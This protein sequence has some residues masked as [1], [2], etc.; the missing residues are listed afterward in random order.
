MQDIFE[1]LSELEQED[2]KEL[3]SACNMSELLN[4]KLTRGIG[5]ANYLEVWL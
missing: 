2:V 3:M 5:R 4:L 1:A